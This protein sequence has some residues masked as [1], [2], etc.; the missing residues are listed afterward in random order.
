[1]L[2]R[3]TMGYLMFACTMWTRV[4]R[5]K[6]GRCCLSA[7]HPRIK[8]GAGEA[9]PIRGYRD[10]LQV[11]R[12]PTFLQAVQGSEAYESFN[13]SWCKESQR[14]RLCKPIKWG[15]SRLSDGK[16]TETEDEDFGPDESSDER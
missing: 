1:M 12:L 5:M 14:Y 9:E 3:L 2:L 13:L 11:Q 6:L 10:N 15:R 7:K 4:L 8:L 16:A